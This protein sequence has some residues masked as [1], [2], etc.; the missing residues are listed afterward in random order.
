MLTKWISPDLIFTY[1]WKDCLYFITG[2]SQ[3]FSPPPRPRALSSPS[4]RCYQSSLC[5]NTGNPGVSYNGAAYRQTSNISH[6]TSQNLNAPRLGLRLSLPKSI[7]AR[8]YVKNEDA[9]REAPTGDAPTT[10]EWS[11]ILLPTNLCL[12]LDVWLYLLWTGVIGT[13]SHPT[14]INKISTDC[15]LSREILSHSYKIDIKHYQLVLLST[16]LVP[17]ISYFF[18]M[19]YWYFSQYT[20]KNSYDHKSVR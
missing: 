8:C 4:I 7:K 11:T 1:T 9:V 17:W 13:M 16:K 6:T 12:I 2:G 14:S 20:T 3:L 15:I 19:S 18:S 10:S 5:M